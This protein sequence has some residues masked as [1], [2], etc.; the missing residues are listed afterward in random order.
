MKTVRVAD[1]PILFENPDVLVINKPAG[2]LVHPTDHDPKAMSLTKLFASKLVQSDPLRPGVVHR[3]D[4]DTSGVMV[5]AKTQT[6]L[7]SLQDQFK[8]REVNKTY[9]ALLWGHLAHSK[10]RVEL[11]IARSTKQPNKMVI[12]Q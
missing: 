1:V 11:P 12:N 4:K 2:I 9:T 6:A 7:K 5:L 10:A 8:N 3:L